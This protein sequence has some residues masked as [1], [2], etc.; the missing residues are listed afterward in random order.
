[1]VREVWS[2]EGFTFPSALGGRHEFS[3]LEEH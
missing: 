2:K 3:N 1:M